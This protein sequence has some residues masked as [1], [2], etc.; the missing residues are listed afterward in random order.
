MRTPGRKVFVIVL[1]AVAGCDGSTPTEPRPPAQL[2]TLPSTLPQPAPSVSQRFELTGT[3]TDQQ[4]TPLAG[5]VV[6]MGLWQVP[7][8]HWPT[9]RAD[10]TGTYWINFTA[11]ARLSDTFLARAQVTADGHEE[12]W[13]NVWANGRTSFVENL[14]VN[15]VTRISAGESIVLSVRP[16]PGEC[17]GDWDGFPCTILRITVAKAGRLT[18]EAMST[19]TA[20]RPPMEICCDRWGNPVTV[21][22]ASGEEL[23]VKIGVGQGISTAQ[24]VTVKTSYAASIGS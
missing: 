23:V 3:V 2:P 16:D 8:P 24:S 17:S 13:R 5:A 18:I 20:V 11:T 19:E 15:R 7:Y 10:K 9:A 21:T 6:T 1:L 14:R 4:G 22:V 12:Y